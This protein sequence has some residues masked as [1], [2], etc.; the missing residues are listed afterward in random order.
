MAK[1][2]RGGSHA[3]L[4]FA[5]WLTISERML[6]DTGKADIY[7]L[8]PMPAALAGSADIHF[9]HKIVQ[10]SRYQLLQIGVFLRPENEQLD[11]V[12]LVFL[13]G[14]L[15]LQEL[16]FLRQL[17][18]FVLIIVGQPAIQRHGKDDGNTAR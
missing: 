7:I 15:L 18:L 6:W 12:S 2:Q 16:H 5:A 9:V 3:V 17:G 13:L 8:H 1:E 14:D 4:L 11:A 10:H